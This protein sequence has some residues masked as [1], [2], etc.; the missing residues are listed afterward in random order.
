MK[1][2][3]KTVILFLLCTYFSTSAFAF[4]SLII[5]NKSLPITVFN[6]TLRVGSADDLTDKKGLANLTARLIRE[7]GSLAW[8]FD[9]QGKKNDEKKIEP[10]FP[11]KTRAEIEEALYP[12]AAEISIEV[13]KE[14]TS[15]SVSCNA[16]DAKIVFSILAQMLL[17]PAF[18]EKEFNRLKNEEIDFLTKRAP[19]EDQEELGKYALNREIFGKT[20]PYSHLEEGT[21]SSLE[22][23]TLDSIKDF[24]KSFYTQKRLIVGLAGVITP[25]LE[26]AVKKAFSQWPM[27][28]KSKAVVPSPQKIKKP[29]LLIVQGPFTATGVHLGSS[30][31]LNRS[32]KDFDDV[33]LAMLGFGKHRS[34]VGRLMSHVR[35]IRSLNYGTYAYIEDFP[36]GGQRHSE[37]T[38]A[39]RQ[40]Q[41]FTLWARPT[42]VENGC[43][44]LRQVYR[45]VQML[46]KDGLTKSEFD[47]AKSHLIGNAPLLATSLDRQ[48]GY[49]I[50]SR[51]YGI[52]GNYTKRLQSSAKKATFTSV[53]KKIKKH[54]DGKGLFIVVVTPDAEK[55][56]SE[57]LSPS[58]EVTYATAKPADVL[59][60]DKI[61]EKYV[62]PLKEEDIVTVNSN[63]LFNQ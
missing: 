20:H 35:E 18:N 40:K 12:L 34:F 39:A 54:I 63:D 24:Y 31:D 48:L 57:I 15:F 33:Y 49:A 56:K 9:S 21:I 10:E 1:L 27:G 29:K 44:L 43:F 19:N 4:E 5:R 6:I 7:G 25:E 38:Q 59:K 46:T 23:I 11:A 41:A 22:K 60:E 3:S 32:S 14:Q 51:F 52:S 42:P 28:T 8:S 13:N 36:Q 55:F 2:N 37:P 17:A 45:E 26:T 47:L 61:I 50:D 53:T 58:C 16:E 62:V 30:T